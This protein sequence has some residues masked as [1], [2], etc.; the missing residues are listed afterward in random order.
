MGKKIKNIAKEK[1]DY[2]FVLKGNK[3]TYYK[4]KI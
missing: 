4:N 2:T 3:T 1:E